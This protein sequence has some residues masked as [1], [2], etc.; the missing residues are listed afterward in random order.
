MIPWTGQRFEN[1]ATFHTQTLGAIVNDMRTLLF[2]F[3]I[4]TIQVYGQDSAFVNE[5]CTLLKS[6][7][8]T[9]DGQFKVIEDQ[10][11]KY[12][13]NSSLIDS[14]NDN[15]LQDFYRFQYKWR[16]E[17]IRT[18]PE[19]TLGEFNVRTQ[20]VIDL[21]DKF[22]KAEID[23]LKE[24]IQKISNENKIYLFLITVDDYFPAN[25]LEEFSNVKREAWGHGRNFEK[26][27]VVIVLSFN[28]RQIRISTSETSMKY[29]TDTECAEIINAMTLEFKKG[30]YYNG[31]V[32]GLDHLKN[33]I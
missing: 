23:S 26:G 29:L 11:L 25:S 9:T 4:V 10:T 19:Y 7:P 2:I 3:F 24:Y 30:N 31:V 12:S 18:C 20:K 28:K 13:L 21:E 1:P 17:L 27:G 15:K 33:K 6:A 14:T 8:A 16:R 32:F 5:T 22:K